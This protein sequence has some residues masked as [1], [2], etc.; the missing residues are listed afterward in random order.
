MVCQHVRGGQTGSKVVSRAQ[1]DGVQ[2]HVG[3]EGVGIVHLE[4][5]EVVPQDLRA[6][7]DA[8]AQL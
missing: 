7:H 5:V 6:Q 3:L 2:L 4:L 1:A 8:I